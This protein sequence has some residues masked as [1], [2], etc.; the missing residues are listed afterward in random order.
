VYWRAC[1]A[2][3]YCFVGLCDHRQPVF[4]G[5][6]GLFR[7][8]IAA[9]SDLRIA[10]TAQPTSCA[11]MAEKLSDGKIERLVWEQWVR[12]TSYTKATAP[13]MRLIT[14]RNRKSVTAVSRWQQVV[15]AK[16]VGNALSLWC[17]SQKRH[18]GCAYIRNPW[19]AGPRQAG[20]SVGGMRLCVK[21][22]AVLILS[23]EVSRHHPAAPAL[24]GPILH[25]RTGLS[26]ARDRCYALRICLWKPSG[27]HVKLSQGPRN[28]R[29]PE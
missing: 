18:V 10:V 17:H 9:C 25:A 1:A 24:L 28:Y 16:R 19:R 13:S 3:I 29:V 6:Q 12:A 26:A 8:S 20:R 27:P 5:F 23:W 7:R 22:F 15:G 11:A 14:S 4:L 2:R 21:G